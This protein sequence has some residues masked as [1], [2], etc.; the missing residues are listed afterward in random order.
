M[1]A[2]GSTYQEEITAVGPA[3]KIEVRVPGPGR[4]WPSNLG[5]APVPQVII[6]PRHPKGPQSLDIPVDAALLAAGDHNGST[7]YQ[8]ARF[9]GI[10]RNGGRPEVTLEDGIRAVEMGLAA[11]KAAVSGETVRM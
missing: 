11:Q 7:F 3:G 10:V 8:H 2:E 4:F 5:A 6:S 9:L 1:Y